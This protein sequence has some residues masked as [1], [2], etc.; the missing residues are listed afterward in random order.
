MPDT[1]R[2][3]NIGNEVSSGELRSDV[4]KSGRAID[5]EDRPSIHC[6]FMYIQN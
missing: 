5:H 6:F 3:R 4:Q 2:D 1:L